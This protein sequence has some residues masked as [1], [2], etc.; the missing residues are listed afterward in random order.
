MKFALRLISANHQLR[1]SMIHQVRVSMIHQ[2]SIQLRT[3]VICTLLIIVK[4]I[5]NSVHLDT[6][7]QSKN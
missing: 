4:K 7:T 5:I 2:V 1:V 3:R 6:H